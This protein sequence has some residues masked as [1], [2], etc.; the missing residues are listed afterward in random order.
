MKKYVWLHNFSK[1]VYIL[2]KKDGVESKGLEQFEEKVIK[3]KTV[4]ITTK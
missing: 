3:L 1:K 4:N 2:S